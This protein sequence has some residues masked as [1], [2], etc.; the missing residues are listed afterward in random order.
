MTVYSYPFNIS[1]VEINS[2]I[3]ISFYFL[4]LNN[5]Y[6]KNSVKYFYLAC[7]NIKKFEGTNITCI[8]IT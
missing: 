8:I 1:N 4:Y 7:V 6:I 3:I 5:M 2:G